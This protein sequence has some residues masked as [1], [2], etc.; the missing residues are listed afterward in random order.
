[1]G[2]PRILLQ[3]DLGQTTG[4]AASARAFQAPTARA[5]GALL[6]RDLFE[7]ALTPARAVVHHR[8]AVFAPH[9]HQR[10]SRRHRRRTPRRWTTSHRPGRRH[11]RRHRLDRTLRPLLHRILLRPTA[12]DYDVDRR[13]L[14]AV[15]ARRAPALLVAARVIGA[16]GSLVR[17]GRV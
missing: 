10:T 2:P 16:E 8:A 1:M 5:L 12:C 13:S 4:A 7:T 11:G 15:L 9:G 17:A 6:E 3:F 14:A